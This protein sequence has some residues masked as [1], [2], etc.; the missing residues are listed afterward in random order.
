LVDAD[1]DQ[2]HVSLLGAA[3]PSPSQTNAISPAEPNTLFRSIPLCAEVE[4]PSPGDE[5][6]QAIGRPGLQPSDYR[7]AFHKVLLF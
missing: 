6:A 7:E 3:A 5:F 2:A 1:D 4:R